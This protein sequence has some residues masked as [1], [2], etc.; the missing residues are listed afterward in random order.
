MD[1][2]NSQQKERAAL[3]LR[4]NN[5]LPLSG[6]YSSEIKQLGVAWAYYSGKIEG[7]TY[8][9][10]ETEAL[11]SD[12][13]TSTKRYEDAKALK[14]L[15]NTF[16]NEL[17]YIK[18]GNKEVIDDK[19]I[20]RLHMNFTEDLISDEERGKFRHRPVGITGTE[21]KPPKNQQEIAL[22]FS[23][24]LFNMTNVKDV[25]ER[26]VYLHLNMAKLQPFVDG[27]KRTSRMLESIVLMNHDIVPIYS[28]QDKDIIEYRKGLIDFYETDNYSTYANYFLDKKL[29]QLQE[30]TS[31]KLGSNIEEKEIKRRRGR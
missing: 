2:F 25:L 29:A 28:T 20:F 19:L 10:V 8:T 5:L 9:Y 22:K 24:I 17:G 30:M 27:N 11:L 16:M 21:Y 18:E 6:L 13:I 7:N 3:I 14:N 12:G 31:E 15:Y 1:I 26:A 4:N 23:E